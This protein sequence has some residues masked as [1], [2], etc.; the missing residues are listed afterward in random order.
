MDKSALTR[1]IKSSASTDVGLCREENQDNYLIYNKEFSFFA[2]ADGMGG[3]GGGATASKMA[4]TLLE[5][6]L[7]AFIKLNP[8]AL[9]SALVEINSAIF[10]IGQKDSQLS[11]MGTTLSALAFQGHELLILNIGDSRSYRIRSGAI[12]QLTRDH[13]LA[14]ELYQSGSI[15]NDQI[16]SHP[17]SHMLTRSLGPL[18]TIEPDCWWHRAS[19]LPKDKFLICSDGLYNLVKANEIA[20][21]VESNKNI[22]DTCQKLISLANQRGG[23]D[24]ITVLIIEVSSKYK[25]LQIEEVDSLNDTIK[26]RQSDLDSLVKKNRINKILGLFTILFFICVGIYFYKSDFNTANSR[27]VKVVLSKTEKNNID[28]FFESLKVDNSKSGN[29][30]RVR[31]FLQR[32]NELEFLIERY[33]RIINFFDLD[34]SKNINER[35]KK[36][37]D[38]LNLTQESIG[39]LKIKIED[40][41][42]NLARWYSY[43]NQNNN[44]LLIK[45]GRELAYDH[46]KVNASKEKFEDNSWEY[47]NKLEKLR[48]SKDENKLKELE[49]LV[50][51][52]EEA[53]EELLTNIKDVLDEKIQNLNQKISKLTID[54]YK[55]EEEMK[56]L[57]GEYQDLELALDSKNPKFSIRLKE[58][59]VKLEEVEKE[60]LALGEYLN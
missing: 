51:K 54:K 34:N 7:K 57:L 15:N 50:V 58:L 35:L 19:L 53:L 28:S 21:I 2:V 52:R 10:D 36:L 12:S 26:L 5:E 30:P 25:P 60:K 14:N 37:K 40:E 1:F 24:N 27:Q 41:A 59:K 33:N 56:Y 20:E 44:N 6:K 8:L 31:N 46:A 29:I 18:D 23:T 49:S 43:K 32:M 38:E 55:L 48:N 47:L 22:D 3:V 17:S 4:I 11:G 13:T 16:D 42:S 9:V 39:K 45:L